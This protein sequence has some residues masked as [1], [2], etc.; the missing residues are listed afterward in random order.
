MYGIFPCVNPISYSVS[1]VVELIAKV[2]KRD[3]EISFDQRKVGLRSIWIPQ[4]FTL[5]ELL[6]YYPDINLELGI[7]MICQANGYL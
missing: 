1:E 6:R 3:V 4:D 2:L 5:Y 7:K